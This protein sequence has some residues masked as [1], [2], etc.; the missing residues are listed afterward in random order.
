MPSMERATFRAWS[1]LTRTKTE[2]GE[3]YYPDKPEVHYVYDN[4]VA[5]G[6]KVAVGD[7]AVVRDSDQ[8]LGAGWIESIETKP[9]TKIIYRCPHC[10]N[11]SLKQR[12]RKRPEYYCDKCRSEF[13]ERKEDPPMAVEVFTA[14]YARTFR[15]AEVPIPV[16]AIESLYLS[17]SWLNSIRELD[18]SRVRPLLRQLAGVDMLWRD[19]VK[20]ADVRHIA[21]GH[22][23]GMRKT[24][25][26]QGQF[27]DE[28]IARYGNT[29]AFT[30]PQP[31]KALQAAHLYLY[32][33]IAEHD[34]DGGLLLRADLHS[35]FDA[36]LITV[37]PD[38]WSIQVAP[39][40]AAYPELAALQGKPL[41][42]AEAR[43]PRREYIQAHQAEAR[44]R[45]V[46]PKVG[47]P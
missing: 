13:D 22:G 33:E 46:L 43:R 44:S 23:I 3:L 45:W 39:E 36:W 6:R 20:D 5:N 47:G 17:R 40:L 10:G 24:R 11:P 4:T 26:G 8:L 1:L 41:H 38:S 25:R 12:S 31:Q 27:R 21:G 7:L 32:S 29:C 14:N 18:A 19:T 15:R 2:S 37:D 30:G 35:L 16:A 42:V 9:G 28:M 34:L